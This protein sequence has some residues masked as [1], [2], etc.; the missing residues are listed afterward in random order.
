MRRTFFF[1]V[2]A[3]LFF[4]TTAQ[5]SDSIALKITAFGIEG[6]Y[7]EHQ[8][9]ALVRVEIRNNTGQDKTVTIRVYEANM[10]AFARPARYSYVEAIRLPAGGNRVL[11]VP[12]HLANN[13]SNSVLYA[14][15]LDE[16]G[17]PVGHAAQILRRPTE[18]KVIGLVCASDEL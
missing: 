16:A 4:A 17:M 10:N 13:A 8:S 5:S 15:A 9:V 12:L 2:F 18:G 14:E 3:F 6:T 7:W 1:V 11:D